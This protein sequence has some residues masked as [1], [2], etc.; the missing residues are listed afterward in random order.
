MYLLV[1]YSAFHV[2]I[3]CLDEVNDLLWDAIV[4]YQFKKKLFFMNAVKGSVFFFCYPGSQ[5]KMAD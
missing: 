2:S 3:C 1:K 4:A 5:Y